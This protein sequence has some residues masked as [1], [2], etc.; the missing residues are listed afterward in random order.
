[1]L[2][3]AA[4]QYQRRHTQNAQHGGAGERRV[5]LLR[6]LRLLWGHGAAAA[7]A[8][9]GRLAGAG[10]C[11]RGCHCCC[12]YVVQAQVMAALQV[13]VKVCIKM[14]EQLHPVMHVT[15]QQQRA[16]GC[17]AAQVGTSLLRSSASNQ[18]ARRAQAGWNKSRQQLT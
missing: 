7:C 17:D 9:A 14:I 8:A 4:L 18:P 16:G 5:R 1:M 10:C 3:G 11:L 15:L 13:F 6:L 12:L 2:V